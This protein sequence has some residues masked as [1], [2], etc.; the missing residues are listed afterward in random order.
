[1]RR[2]TR[3]R[4]LVCPSCWSPTLLASWVVY[5]GYHRYANIPPTT[6]IRREC[7]WQD[8]Q[9]RSSPT[10]S[11]CWADR[12][13]EE[14]ESRCEKGLLIISPRRR[15][16]E[17]FVSGQRRGSNSRPPSIFV[18]WSQGN[19]IK[20]ANCLVKC[21]GAATCSLKQ[22][23]KLLPSVFKALSTLRKISEHMASRK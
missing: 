1:M 6:T 7:S 21:E 8:S 4:L 12:A 17:Q 15:K 16:R 11:T 2:S 14:Q 20:L 9:P 19:L 13:A 5:L 10:A 22:N 3:G 18:R 23:G